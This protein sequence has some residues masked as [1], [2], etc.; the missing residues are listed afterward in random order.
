MP[1]EVILSESDESNKQLNVLVVGCLQ[2]G[3]ST[4]INNLFFQK[5]AEESEN[6]LIRYK[7][8]VNGVTYTIFDL[9]GLKD[10]NDKAYLNKV[11]E[12]CPEIH[13]VIYCTRMDDP[14]R[15]DE[16]KALRNITVVFRKSI[17]EHVIIALTFANK[18]EPADPDQ[19]EVDFFQETLQNQKLAL[20]RHFEQLRIKTKVVEVLSK[21]IIPA[22]SRVLKLPGI[23]NW[24]VDFWRGCEQACQ[25]EGKGAIFKLSQGRGAAIIGTVSAF[26]GAGCVAA[27]VG[28][29]ATGIWAPLGV[30]LIVCGGLAT[31]AGVG[32]VVAGAACR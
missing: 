23:E 13:L 4:L 17:W 26:A 15:P 8:V 7:F 25:P 9:H 31:T 5:T 29:I 28:L 14:I 3:K 24:Q 16:D 11:K 22:G 19:D 2:V 21:R 18:M 32:A 10:R 27:G 1:P 20:R 6:L 30:A 12:A